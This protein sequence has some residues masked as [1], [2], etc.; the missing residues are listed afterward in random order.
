MDL[1]FHTINI[2]FIKSLINQLNSE[3]GLKLLKLKQDINST[4]KDL[5][6]K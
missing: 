4:N 1:N 6:L 5:M 2:S 3:K